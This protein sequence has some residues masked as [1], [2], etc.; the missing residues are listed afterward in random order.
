[1]RN[2]GLSAQD[3]DWGS[4]LSFFMH[5]GYSPDGS[6]ASHDPQTKPGDYIDLTAEMDIIVAISACPSMRNPCNAYNPSSMQTVIFDPD[7]EYKAKVDALRESRQVER[8]K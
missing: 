6:M 4:C 8:H 7:G 3:I 5:M 2:Y 1:M